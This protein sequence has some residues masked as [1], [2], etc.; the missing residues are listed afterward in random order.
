MTQLHKIDTS[1][2]ENELA[3][4]EEEA[5][6]DRAQH[7]NRDWRAEA[8]QAGVDS[9]EVLAERTLYNARARRW[10]ARLTALNDELKRRAA[11]DVDGK[12]DTLRQQHAAAW[13]TASEALDS[14]DLA[15][16]DALEAQIDRY[17]A[18][19]GEVRSAAVSAAALAREHNAPAP[20]L[21]AAKAEQVEGLYDR[22]RH[23]AER[24]GTPGKQSRQDLTAHDI[25]RVE[26]AQEA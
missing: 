3:Q 25:R 17:L 13:Q 24:V 5:R 11:A 21:V 7:A 20:V 15:A 18:A 22:L 6:Q 14:V 4:V 2:L 9:D 1:A 12:L 8:E 19:A 26:L 16:L 10:D 23:L